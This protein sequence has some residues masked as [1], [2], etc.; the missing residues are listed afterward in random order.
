[1]FWLNVKIALQ[2]LVANKMRSLLTMLGIIIGV[3]AVI[4]MVSLG[5]VTTYNINQEWKTLGVNSIFINNK[6]SKR[7]GIERLQGAR[8]V[9]TYED[10]KAIE[11]ECPSVLCCSPVSTSSVLTIYRE[12]N[13][14]AAI[15]GISDSFFQ[16]ENLPVESGLLFTNHSVLK[17]GKVCV[18]GKKIADNLFGD[19]DPIDKT[20][21]IKDS[22]F[23]VMA[24][25]KEKGQTGGSSNVDE[26]IYIP[27]T[28]YK[29]FVDGSQYVGLLEAM[30]ATQA[31]IKPAETEITA[32]L[33]ERHMIKE[34]KADDFEIQTMLELL[35]SAQKMLSM[36][37]LFLVFVASIS[38]IVGGIGI[39]NIMLVSVTE[40]IREIGVRM[41]LGAKGKHIMQQFMIESVVLCL[42]GGFIGL[43]FGFLVTIGLELSQKWKLMF[44]PGAVALSLCFSIAIGVIFGFVPAMKASKLDPIEALKA[45]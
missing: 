33:R 1:M 36:L 22:P 10:A 5:Q 15:Y 35:K 29:I 16:I 9:L 28:S 19:E 8:K 30:A 12:Q 25:L 34:G 24:V 3:S 39:M 38:L 23:R 13:W 44:S 6:D 17:R 18:I 43:A 41:A 27:Y 45:E 37:S 4:I 7:T 20:I 2:A 21:R 32:T 14:N 40:R 31:S 11:D 26:R 42:L